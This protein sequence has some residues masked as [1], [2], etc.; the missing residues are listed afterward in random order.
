ME[1]STKTE[2]KWKICPA[3]MYPK[4]AVIGWVIIIGLGLAI[5][6]TN[7]ILGL[8]LTAVLIATQATFLFPSTFSITDDGVIAIYPIRRKHYSWSQ[9]RRVKFFKD[10]CYL[11]SRKKPSNL[12]GWSGMA[13]FYEEN[14]EDVIQAIRDH[15]REGVAT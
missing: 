15:L 2:M 13:L 11:F 9:V 4:K 5:A 14:R 3:K 10:V 12:D 6:S 1:E 7:I 8:C